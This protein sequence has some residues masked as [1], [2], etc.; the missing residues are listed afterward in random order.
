MPTVKVIGAGLA[1]S[2][3]AYQLAKRGIKVK[4][5]E[6]KPVKK[7][8]A[9]KSDGFAELVCSNSLRSNDPKNAVGLLKQEMIALDSL[10]MKAALKTEIPA[11]SSLAVDREAFSRFITE[12]LSNNPNIEIIHEEVTDIDTDQETL[13][14]AGPLCS[15]GLGEEIRKLIGKDYLYF[16]DAVAPIVT[17]ESVDF[18]HAYYKDRYSEEQGDYI[19]CPLTKEEFFAFY[20][21]LINAKQVALREFEKEIY[22]EGCMPFE[23]MA[24]RGFNTLLFGPMKPVGLEKDGVRPFA[25]VQLRKDNAIDTLY[26]IVGFQTHLTFPEQKRILSMVP[27]LKNVEI[28]RYGV[29]HRNNYINSPGILNRYYQMIEYPKIFIAGQISGVEGYVESAAS[30]LYAGINMASSVLTDEIVPLPSATMMGSMSEYISNPSIEKLVPMNANFGIFKAPELKVRK[31]ERR[32]A[33]G[34]IALENIEK[35]KEALN[36]R[37]L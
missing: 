29:M 32:L 20:N 5:Y 9:H 8:P 16:F 30:G 15:E 22:F 19:N 36:A 34:K 31:N 4:L 12:E 10:I 21:E 25:V 33:Y 2:E 17:K 18:D 13:I 26:N 7:S 14:A 28:V 3:A 37:G 23:E 1:G 35:Y 27:A 24:R 11:G 6:M